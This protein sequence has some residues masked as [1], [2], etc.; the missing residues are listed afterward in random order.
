MLY[1][2]SL[3]DTRVTSLHLK[4]YS[5]ECESSYNVRFDLVHLYSN[6]NKPCCI[7]GVKLSRNPTAELSVAELS[8]AQLCSTILLHFVLI[9]LRPKVATE[10]LVRLSR[11]QCVL[12]SVLGPKAGLFPVTFYVVIFSPST[13]CCD[14]F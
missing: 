8:A 1:T 12:G 3:R 11:I 2:T 4:H 10:M 14:S 13:K 9:L 7:I 6:I 5:L